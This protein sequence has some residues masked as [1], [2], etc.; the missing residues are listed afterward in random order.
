MHP[1]GEKRVSGFRV[2]S[3]AL[4]QQG[5][6]VERLPVLVDSSSGVPCKLALRYIARHRRTLVSEKTLVEELRA[7]GRLYD[8]FRT[9]FSV[10]FED[11]VARDVRLGPRELDQLI[12]FL[13]GQEGERSATTVALDTIALNRFLFWVANVQDRGGHAVLPASELRIYERRLSERFR[14]TSRLRQR[15]TRKAPL[16]VEQDSAL[17]NLIGPE[18][19]S[20]G[21]VRVPLR[22]ADNNPWRPIV[23]LRNFVAY[24][25]ARELGLRRGELGK[26]RVDDVEL[27]GNE[28]AIAIRRRPN[29]AADERRTSNRPQ[30]KTVERRLPLSWVAVAAVRQYMRTPL[31]QGGRHGAATPYLLVTA[32]GAPISSTSLDSVWIAVNAA[33]KGLQMSWHTLRHTWAEELAD[34]LLDAHR[35]ELDGAELVLA[36]LRELGGWAPGSSTPF[37]YIQATLRRRGIEFL[38]QRNEKFDDGAKG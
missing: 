9:Q 13:R 18:R 1:V 2:L 23:R 10:E 30:V 25:L 7:V 28:L 24:R 16:T 29:D 31:D 27:V 37:R 35:G 4:P 38:R 5:A 19:R 32:D 21:V 22:F 12:D 14:P 34:Q 3:V 17:A 36:M 15:G 33:Q 8:F 20:D 11:R 6:E 26:L